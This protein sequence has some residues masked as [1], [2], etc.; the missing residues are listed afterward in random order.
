MLQCIDGMQAALL[1]VDTEDPCL[2]VVCYHDP[3]FGHIVSL[4]HCFQ[5]TSII[6]N[7]PVVAE[8]F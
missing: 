1:M 4:C 2:D 7:R 3:V 5:E 6:E 8:T